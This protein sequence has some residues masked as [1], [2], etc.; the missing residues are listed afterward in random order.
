MLACLVDVESKYLMGTRKHQP[1]GSTKQKV[2]DSPESAGFIIHAPQESPPNSVVIFV[3][4][5]I[6]VPT[7]P[8]PIWLK[9]QDYVGASHRFGGLISASCYF[10][11]FY[12]ILK[13]L[14][15]PLPIYVCMCNTI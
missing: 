11:S 6:M 3:D 15:K 1:H 9:I 2:R 12:W 5:H 7:E 8:Q 10:V 4:I 14:Q 13:H